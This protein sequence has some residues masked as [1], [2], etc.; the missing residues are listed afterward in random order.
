MLVLTRKKDE[1]IM[2]GENIEIQ[3]LSIEGNQVQ[4]GIEAPRSI[5][6]HREEIYERIRQE[7]V[8]AA[9]AAGFKKLGELTVDSGE[10]DE[11]R[12]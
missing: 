9:K 3:V 11:K 4:I 10:D 12:E 8:E 5:E 6:V 7:N 2:I 1:K